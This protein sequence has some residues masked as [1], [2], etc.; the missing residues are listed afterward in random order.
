MYIPA[1]N[2]DYVFPECL[3]LNKVKR[4]KEGNKA[5]KS[6]ENSLAASLLMVSSENVFGKY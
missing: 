2:T 1:V 4:V 6:A 5:T 3:Y